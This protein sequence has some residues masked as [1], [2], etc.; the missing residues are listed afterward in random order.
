MPPD[1]SWTPDA[2]RVL[3]RAC[4]FYG[5]ADLWRT[6]RCVRLHLGELQGP[7]PFMKGV[8][9]T[10]PV[11]RVVEVWP[12]ERRATFRDYPHSGASMTFDTVLLAHRSTFR[13]LARYRRWS[14][15]D[16]LYFFGYALWHYHAVPFT[17]GEARLRRH[18]RAGACDVLHVEFPADLPT[19]SRRQAFH[20]DAE[21]RIRRHDYTADIVG[22][23]ARGAHFWRAQTRVNGLPVALERHVVSRLGA[24]ATPVTVLHARFS[25]AE[26]ECDTSHT[27]SR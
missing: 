14:P 23:W 25:G 3:A 27:S 6:L 20:I 19:H 5:G 12:R 4:A 1:A 7:L 16:A 22:A 10:F 24:L 26:V 15:V 11:P 8:G 21:G 9:R 2:A 18:R 17:L 13:G